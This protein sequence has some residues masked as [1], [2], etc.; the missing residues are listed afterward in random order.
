MI[1]PSSIDLEAF[2]CGDAIEGIDG[3]LA[4]CERC[5]HFVDK[6]KALAA[7]VDDAQVEAILARV[8]PA[9]DHDRAVKPAA[10][11]SRFW[12]VASTVITPLAA[13]AAI[14]LLT[15]SAP[16]PQPGPATTATAMTPNVPPAPT[17]AEITPPGAPDLGTTFKGSVQLAVVR[18]RGGAQARFLGDVEVRSGDRLRVE[19]ALDREQAILGAVIA[20]D[21][22]YLEIMPAGTR[23]RGTHYSER[24]ARIDAHPI[25]GTIVIGTP[26]AVARARATMKFDGVVTMRVQ[27]EG[28]WP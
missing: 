8:A 1:H 16:L 4:E 24:S 9:N 19:V 10:A 17:T 18:E 28:S 2:A 14:V 5:R 25:A 11:R 23:G 22:A 6:A 21:G 3:H 15:R 13:A 7:T 27:P 20:D 26:E 12:F